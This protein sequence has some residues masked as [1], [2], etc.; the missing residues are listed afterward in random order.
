MWSPGTACND[1]ADGLQ[2][3]LEVDVEAG[4]ELILVVAGFNGNRGEHQLNIQRMALNDGPCP[5]VIAAQQSGLIH[6]GGAEGR[7]VRRVASCGGRRTRCFGVFTMRPTRI[8]TCFILSGLRQPLIYVF[9]GCDGAELG[10]S[11]DF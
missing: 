11:R 3:R 9:D 2:S 5:D 4:D 7:F 1:D 8:N 6:E 10:C